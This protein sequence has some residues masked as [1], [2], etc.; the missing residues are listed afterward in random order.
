[1]STET[2]TST[3]VLRQA[4]RARA[5]HGHL[6]VLARDLGI[7]V[8]TLEDFAHGRGQLDGARLQA[9]ATDL[10]C[11]HVM[12]DPA[13][14]RLRS[15]SKSKPKPLGI[16]PPS[17]SEMGLTLPTFAGGP[18]PPQTGYGGGAKPKTT[19]PGWAKE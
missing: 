12:Y 6:G 5:M 11:G 8:M 1:M 19:R 9:L 15:V 3:D 17:V 2:V 10:F 7:G 4:L 13:V 14:D 16:I 18:P